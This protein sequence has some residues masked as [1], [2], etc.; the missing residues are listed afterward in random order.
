MD[1]HD[2]DRR[3][4]L[5]GAFAAVVA[6][7]VPSLFGCSK[8]ETP[9][10]EPAPPGPAPGADAAAPGGTTPETSPSAAA[11]GGTAKVAKA[12]VQYQEQ[13]KGDQNCSNCLQFVPESS[14]CKVVE[15]AIK[16]EGWC[17]LWT[18]KV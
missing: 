5:H 13:P 10:V 16:P 7:A 3:Q 9:P 11:P 6:L 12:S 14:T 2:Q 17:I 18:R 8:R 15:G 4:M 1:T